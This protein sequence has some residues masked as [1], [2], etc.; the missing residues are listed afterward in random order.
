MKTRLKSIITI[1]SLCCIC[2]GISA[3]TVIPNDKETI[4][5]KL[6][7]GMT[8]YL[9][10][11]AN[12]A[13]CADFY[14]VHNVGALQEED[15]Q[16][17]L[18]HF[19]EHMAFNGTKHY[20]EKTLLEFLAKEGVR[21]GYNVNAYTSKNETVYNISDVPLVRESFVDSVLM[22]LHDWSCD[23]SCEQ[24]AL[25][26]ERGVISE[27]WR[28]RD[29]TRMR[30]AMKQMNLTYR[31]SKHTQRSVLGTLEV[32]NGFKRQDI[33]DFYHKW[34]RPDLQAIIVVGDFNAD[35]ME[36]RV[37]RLFSDIPAVENPA[38][39]EE[40]TIP[41][42]TE[43]L[44]EHMTDPEIK[45]M[46]LKVIHKQP[47]PTWEERGT[48][49]Y[50]KDLNTRQIVS[51]IVEERFRKAAQKADSPVKNA[52]LVTSPSGVDFYQSMFT[53]SPKNEDLF[54][55]TVAFYTREMKRVLEYGISEDEFNAAKDLVAKKYRLNTS[56]SDSDVRNRDIV[57]FCKENFL[58]NIPC[59]F[60]T[61]YKVLQKKALEEVTYDEAQSYVEKMFGESE[62]IY[63]CSI[64]D[65]K[66][67]KLPS[68]E[69]IIE[70]MEETGKEVVDPEFI[71]YEKL[72]LSTDPEAGTITK[73]GKIKGYEGEIW[74][75]SNGAKVY[76]IP[77][78]PVQADNHLAMT[79]HF[80][81]GYSA[82]PQDKIGTSICAKSYIERYVGLSNMDNSELRNA[83]G[84]DGITINSRI[85]RKNASVTL[86]SDE[87]GVENS[88][89]MIY[90]KLTQ[91]NFSDERTFGKFKRDNYSNMKQDKSNTD[92][93]NVEFEK[94]KYGDYPWLVDLGTSD[95]SGLDIDFVKKIYEACF[96]DFKNMTVYVCSDLDKD[97][98]KGLV[99]KYIASLKTDYAVKKAKEQ[100]MLPV[101]RKTTVL[102]KTYPVASV[103]KSE[104]NYYFSCKAKETTEMSLTIDILDYIMSAR[105][106]N[107][108]REARGGTYHVSYS[109]ERYP[110]KR[111]I[112]ESVVFFQTRPEMTDI[113][114][115]DVDIL[116]KE[117]AADGPTSDEMDAAVKY[118]IKRDGENNA[119]NAN[120]IGAKLDEC[121]S[122]VKYGVEYDFDYK[123]MVE[124]ITKEDVRKLAEKL[125]NGNKLVSIY[126][127][128]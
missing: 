55:E 13:G 34:Y 57:N 73:T 105:C 72:D 44:I 7:N 84:I 109:T 91:P 113:L 35:E 56:M 62:K 112:L 23:I 16:N 50:L 69:R 68:K 49:I 116:M 85:Y 93:F 61:E 123:S 20:P 31:G 18:A 28:R 120:S 76:W 81:T 79:M 127:E 19:L 2:Q 121:I 10:H 74:T 80:E 40:Y 15:S 124:S 33:L 22:I 118:L 111:D 43:P 52:I 108:I 60:P 88:F 26:A 83:P 45:Y 101:Y 125:Y 53:I 51:T 63:S 114:V 64:N 8:Y 29:D 70:I 39:K 78:A 96:T 58:R 89:K 36:K 126:R 11:N 115:S 86:L 1:L 25:D 3:Q 41:H 82:F 32:I 128:L 30:M 87:K 6:D 14:I 47:F 103:V 100:P 12:P 66:I 94:A 4:I 122:Y 54:D 107:Q 27:E 98:I 21:F 65:S 90:L 77:S 119:K 59:V 46:T 106:L 104:V 9:R 75:L 110:D 117:M 17:G 5:G 38:P 67:E 92:L 97:E 95:I 48:D 24:D 102:D 71:T 37:R 99:E 42:L